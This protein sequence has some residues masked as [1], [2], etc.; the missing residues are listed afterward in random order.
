MEE[1]HQ[2]KVFKFVDFKP[3]HIFRFLVG[4]GAKSWALKHGFSPI[5][6]PQELITEESFINWK[7]LMEKLQTSSNPLSNDNSTE[8]EFEQGTTLYDTI[9]AVCIDMYGNI[10]SGISSGGIL[11]KHSGRIGQ[12]GH[13]GSGCWAENDWQTEGFPGLACCTSGIGEFLM[14]SM[15]AKDLCTTLRLMDETTEALQNV[16]QNLLKQSPFQ[17]KKLFGFMGLKVEDSRLQIFWGHT[18]SSMLLAYYSDCQS[19]PI[20]EMSYLKSRRDEGKKYQFGE[21]FFR[22]KRKGNNKFVFFLLF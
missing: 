10:A 5:S 15:C 17:K 16:F 22:Y 13:I 2:C 18:T 4:E 6:S 20:S 19:K 12:G 9:G 7:N 11:L 8:I 14:Q 3:S 1:S 21:T